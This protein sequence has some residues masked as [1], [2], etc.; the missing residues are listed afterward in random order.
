MSTLT[1]EWLQQTISEI[2]AIRDEVPFGLDEHES[3]ML[4][5]LNLAL[6]SLEAEPVAW[7]WEYR[8]K[9]H[10]TNDP[11]RAK[12]VAQDGDVAVQPLFTA[13]PAPASVPDEIKKLKDGRGFKYVKD[14]VHYS[15]NYAN[16]WN[17]CR[18]AMLQGAEPVT[19]ANKLLAAAPQQEV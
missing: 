4:E 10:V 19:T 12:F 5:V 14:G 18:A 8:D 2:E 3:N 1:K 17:Q 9:N 7:Q 11:A 13:P 15:V 6:A 16:G